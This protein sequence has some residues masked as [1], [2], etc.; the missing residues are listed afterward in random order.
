MLYTDV[1]VDPLAHDRT[2]SL[3]RKIDATPMRLA[4]AK[5]STVA[6]WF[7]PSA[8]ETSRGAS[9]ELAIYKLPPVMSVSGKVALGRVASA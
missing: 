3:L 1:T 5:G 6:V 8:A 7:A 9:H 2:S 4:V